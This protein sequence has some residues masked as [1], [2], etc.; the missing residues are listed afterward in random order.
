MGAVNQALASRIVPLPLVGRDQD[1]RLLRTL[2]D[3]A[4]DGQ[5]SLALISGEAG[6]GKTALIAAT[7]R[8]ARARGV[9]VAVGY[10]YDRSV[11]PP[12][13]P[14]GELTDSQREEL[15]P[16]INVPSTVD[17]KFDDQLVLF[18]LVTEALSTATEECPLVVVLED[19]HWSDPASL[20]LLRHVARRVAE[21][22]LLLIATYRSDGFTSADV[23][24]A[25]LP[26][27]VRE[28]DA[29]RIDLQRLGRGPLAELIATRY[30][31]PQ[32][33]HERLVDHVVA[34]SEGN[35]LFAHEFLR[36]L[37]QCSV[38]Q[39]AE[40]GWRLDDVQPTHV[41][42][43]VRQVI[44]GRLLHLNAQTR[45][46][47]EIAA[48]IGHSV[49][50]DLWS[51]VTDLSDEQLD[52]VVTQAVGACL[53]EE[54]ADGRGWQFSHALVHDT[55]Y[56]RVMLPR[57]RQWHRRIAE[58]LATIEEPD[59]GILAY[60]FNH[61]GD[62]RA[63]EWHLRAGER[64]ERLYAT[65]TAV[66][67]F[68]AVLDASTPTVEQRLQAHRF[69]GR[70][71]ETLGEFD[72]AQDDFDASIFLARQASDRP[73]EVQTLLDMG[74]LW[75]SRN[76]D[77]AGDY[78]RRALDLAR[79][80]G[81]R[82]MLARALNHVGNWYANNVDNSRDAQRH[83]REALTL[84]EELDD[85][86]GTAE[87][88]DL[89]GITAMMIGDSAA[90]A[91]YY[92]RAVSI[93]REVGDRKILSSS[94]ATFAIVP[95][96]SDLSAVVPMI[97]SG[98]DWRRSGTEALAI[99][100][101]MNWRAGEAYALLILGYAQAS[102][103]QYEQALRSEREAIA[104]AT[105]IGHLYWL[106]GA[107][108]TIGRV[109]Y[110]LLDLDTAR[111][112][113]ECAVRLAHEMRAGLGI[114][115][116]TALLAR[117]TTELGDLERADA[118]LRPL[119]GQAATL[120][121]SHA[122]RNCWLAQAALLLARSEPGRA[123]DLIDRVIDATP[124]MTTE[125]ITPFVAR[126]RAATL[127]ALGRTRDAEAQLQ[128]GCRSAV[129]FQMPG[130][131][132]RVQLDLGRLYLAARRHDDAGREL[133]AAREIVDELAGNTPEG[134]MRENFLQRALALFPATDSPPS[135]ATGSPTIRLSPREIEVLT[136][137]SQGSTDQEIAD[138]LA[139]RHRTVTTHV[140]NIF[141]KLGVN[142]RT[143]AA[144][145]AIRRDLV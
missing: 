104:I 103:G 94:L 115:T 63:A 35:P 71:H 76:Y 98:I 88:L 54:S 84:F 128:D 106:T 48:V 132:W 95:I 38:L 127:L 1:Q 2:L 109:Q 32:A 30:P 42:P 29:T 118:L 90:A 14:W 79:T 139:I 89:L 16:Q 37:E 3:R 68:T 121:S 40:S 19:M 134:E 60:H 72:R 114:W 26:I 126:Q 6:I 138:A 53:L 28:S 92:Q 137:L 64:A 50:L 140:T 125:Y 47:L 27:L 130:H 51:R 25:L 93:A 111:V 36:M 15:V 75:A 43:L 133:S 56:E 87:T 22:S 77:R 112:S 70:V 20:E 24:Y 105:E 33:D 120:A 23:L 31:L 144:S 96:P 13:G 10:C 34:R 91:E 61:A 11:T 62:P 108:E 116:D 12:Y 97:D 4:V 86:H 145:L 9:H 117:V 110:L 113:L 100:R 83:H 52:A 58:E 119:L 46:A 41:P 8:E 78:Y 81:D 80:D 74:M 136:L 124:G 107:H 82:S 67:H 101:D 49:P 17:P 142:T 7:S 131:L 55:C 59:P 57:R 99:A 85:R 122:L 129:A 21:M 65:Q 44:D 5:G 45:S 66:M 102:T 73:A 69:R 123:L 39:R 143:A 141:N 135:S 18:N